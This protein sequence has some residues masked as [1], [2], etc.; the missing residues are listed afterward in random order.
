M[1]RKTQLYC[2]ATAILLTP[3]DRIL[4]ARQLWPLQSAVPNKVLAR[5]S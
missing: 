5:L 3:E 1:D 4:G 2:Y